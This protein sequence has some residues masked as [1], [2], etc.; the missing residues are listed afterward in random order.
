MPEPPG[1]RELSR[2][3]CFHHPTREAV[4]VC[5]ECG[6][7]FCRECI[8]EHEDRVIC[9]HC[10]EAAHSHAPVSRRFTAVYRVLAFWGALFFLWLFFYYWGQLLLSLPASF[11]EGTLWKELLEKI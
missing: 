6:H 1:Q 8:T 7:Y 9:A 11:H 3:R 5:P 4:A 2:K 10:L